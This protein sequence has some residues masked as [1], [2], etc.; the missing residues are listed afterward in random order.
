RHA[1]EQLIALGVFDQAHERLDLRRVLHQVARRLHLLGRQGRQ[2]IEKSEIADGGHGARTG[3]A[4]QKT[5]T[6][7]GPLLQMRWSQSECRISE[8]GHWSAEMASGALGFAVRFGV[9]LW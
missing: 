8:N 3:R 9:V 5:A 2:P 4:R 1:L 7:H 6:V